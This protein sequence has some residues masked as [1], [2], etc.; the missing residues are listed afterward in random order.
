MKSMV[1]RGVLAVSLALALAGGA[2]ATEKIADRAT[3]EPGATTSEP[4]AM[5]AE[6]MQESSADGRKTMEEFIKSDRAP[7]AM[8]K[9]MEMAR[10]MG[11]GDAMVGM[12]RMM[13]MMGSMNGGQGGMMQPGPGK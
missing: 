5:C 3:S 6:M 9:M 11:N 12:T 2:M 8:A 4:G 10:R 13:E 7:Q 1:M